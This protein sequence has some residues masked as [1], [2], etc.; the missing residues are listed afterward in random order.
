MMIRRQKNMLIVTIF[1]G[2]L[3][4]G[5]VG[6]E[7]DRDTSPILPGES[8]VLVVTFSPD[9]V[10]ENSDKEF[11]FPIFV[12]EV[13][14]VGATITSV[15]IEL[16]DSSGTVVD[17]DDHDESWVRRTF[18]TSHIEP[19]G[20][21][22]TKVNLETSYSAHR[23]SWVLRGIDDKDHSFEFSNSIELIRR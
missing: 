18:G 12:D 4:L 7:T 5:L 17:T 22:I 21:L 3:G 9:P 6:C 23:E 13:N 15:K 1:I 20:R 10:H 8:T 2:F 16:L 19:F 11:H 14:N